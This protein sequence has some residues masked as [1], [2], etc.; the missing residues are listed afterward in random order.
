[1]EKNAVI[2]NDLSK[3]G[4]NCTSVQILGQKRIS[5]LVYMFVRLFWANVDLIFFSCNTKLTFKG[6]LLAFNSAVLVDW[7]ISKMQNEF[8]NLFLI[9][10]L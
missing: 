4:M 1:M 2:Q 7:E 10:P 3:G 8:E 5:I 6:K 9:F